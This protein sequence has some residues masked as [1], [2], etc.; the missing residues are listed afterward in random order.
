M[1]EGEARRTTTDEDD[2]DEWDV[3]YAKLRAAIDDPVLME[4]IP[5]PERARFKEMAEQLLEA[6]ERQELYARVTAGFEELERTTRAGA[7]EVGRQLAVAL[8]FEELGQE[9]VRPEVARSGPTSFSRPPNDAPRSTSSR[10]PFATSTPAGKASTSPVRAAWMRGG[11]GGHRGAAGGRPT[12]SSTCA[13]PRAAPTSSSAAARGRARGPLRPL[14]RAGQGR[15]QRGP[16]RPVS[17]PAEARG[18]R[19]PAEGRRRTSDGPADRGRHDP[20]RRRNRWSW[21]TWSAT[22]SCSASP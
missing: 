3:D 15:G 11:A 12:G 4:K 20:L 14:P 22:S 8:T 6:H 17:G 16:E 2:D 13:S 9:A 21:T 10:S 18:M 19:S 5:E 7:E 1:D